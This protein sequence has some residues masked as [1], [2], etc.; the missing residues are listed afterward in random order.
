MSDLGQR[1]QDLLAR[2][3]EG[4]REAASALLVEYGPRLFESLKGFSRR[5]EARPLTEIIESHSRLGSSP[6]NHR[7]RTQRTP[8][9]E[10]VQADRIASQIE[11]LDDA[12]AIEDQLESLGRPD[13]QSTPL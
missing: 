5:P 9:G 8:P 11:P 2:I 6:N 1:I 10:I 3:P 4:Q 7:R 13:R 12:A